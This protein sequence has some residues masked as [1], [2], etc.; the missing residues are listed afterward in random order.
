M[1]AGTATVRRRRS[2]I[3]QP[4]ILGELASKA[5]LCCWDVIGDSEVVPRWMEGVEVSWMQFVGTAPNPL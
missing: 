5:P 4:Y 2:F 3:V 1:A